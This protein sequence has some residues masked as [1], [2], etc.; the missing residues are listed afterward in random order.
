MLKGRGGPGVVLK[1]RGGPDAGLKGKGGGPGEGC[2]RDRNLGP[3]PLPYRDKSTEG[4]PAAGLGIIFICR[5]LQRTRPKAVVLYITLGIS[6]DLK[7]TIRLDSSICIPLCVCSAL[8]R[9]SPCKYCILHV[10]DCY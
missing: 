5:S 3:R 1:G 7:T 2:A 10:A 6:P 9:L 4:T 8:Y